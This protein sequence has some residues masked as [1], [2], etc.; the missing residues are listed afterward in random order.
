MIFPGF[1]G[2]LSFFQVFQ[3]EWEPCYLL[4]T[5]ASVRSHSIVLYSLHHFKSYFLFIFPCQHRP[6]CGDLLIY[7]NTCTS[8]CFL[9]MS[10]CRQALLVVKLYFVVN[11]TKTYSEF[12]C[13]FT[14][15]PLYGLNAKLPF[16]VEIISLCLERRFHMSRENVSDS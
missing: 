12:L 6:N 13:H 3:V 1:P 5:L 15:K 11:H 2:V 9:L 16:T 7:R 10:S 4:L 8:P 14:Q